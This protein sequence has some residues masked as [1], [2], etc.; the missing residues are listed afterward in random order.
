MNGEQ[1]RA[2]QPSSLATR[3]DRT[4]Q[5]HCVKPEA[6]F[7]CSLDYLDCLKRF[8]MIGTAMAEKNHRIKCKEV[9]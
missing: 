6:M 7:H 5:F 1:I 2:A 4:K 9:S 8:K 3:K